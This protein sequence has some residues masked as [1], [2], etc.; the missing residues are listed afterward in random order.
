MAKAVDFVSVT[1]LTFLLTFVW[2]TLAFKNAI[3]SLVFSIVIALTISV[4]I[5]R[6]FKSKFNPYTYDRLEF[7]FCVQGNEYVI[8][9]LKSI[10]K[11]D[12]IDNG[13][14]YILL[15]NA[16]IV[17]NYKFSQLGLQDI[18]AVCNLAIKH[19]RQRVYLLTKGIDR[20]A[21][22]VAGQKN[23]KISTVKTKEVFKYL[24][25]HSALP[26]LKPIKTKYS[27]KRL[28]QIALSRRNFRAYAFSG[29]ILIL[30]SFITPLKIYYMVFGSISILLALLSLTPLGNGELTSPKAFEEL[31]RELEQEYVKE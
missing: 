26:D 3:V 27:F 9:L 18:C 7:E 10:T 11:N 14:N 17:A 8:N 13:S 29:V 12:K 15:N 19:E 28:I 25:K 31:E 20:R 6:V 4:L 5:V 2:A 21:Y 23:V 22:L 1:I 16:I 30:T 24:K